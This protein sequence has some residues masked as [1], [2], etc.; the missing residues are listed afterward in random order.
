MFA[1]LACEA[2][3]D[4]IADISESDDLWFDDLDDERPVSLGGD[5]ADDVPGCETM[6]AFVANRYIFGDKPAWWAFDFSNCGPNPGPR[7]LV[8]E[9]LDGYVCE[10]EYDPVGMSCEII[11]MD[12]CPKVAED[13]WHM[14]LWTQGEDSISLNYEAVVPYVKG[15]YKPDSISP[16]KAQD[17]WGETFWD[18]TGLG[19]QLPTCDPITAG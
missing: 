18:C 12:D 3:D 2:E 19:E 7:L 15:D 1:P 13:G 16:C 10:Q 9:T 17:V 11:T 4:V 8:W 5:A 14:V 6:E